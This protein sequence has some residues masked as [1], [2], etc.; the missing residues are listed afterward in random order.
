MAVDLSF[1]PAVP[2]FDA[3]V[4]LG[5]RYDRAVSVDTAAGTLTEMDRLGVQRALVYS[6]HAASFDTAEGNE[7]LLET[8]GEQSRLVPQFVANPAYDDLSSF[9]AGVKDAGVR[10]IRMYPALHF[11][12][13]RDWMIGPWLA[14]LAAEELPVWLPVG[15]D[16]SLWP[17]WRFDSNEVYDTLRASPDVTAVLTEVVYQQFSWAIPLVRSLPNLYVELS[18]W[19][20]IDGIPRLL[21]AVGDERILYGSRFPEG[22][23]GPQLYN[24]H[25]HGFSEETLGRICSGNLERLLGMR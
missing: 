12:P 8:I 21:E 11:Y 2:V 10:S 13:F 5:R 17:P 19:V 16:D 15:Y 3:N 25:H 20:M 22:A 14:W 24:L 4:A 7:I 1:K 9:A 23:M 18:R 6:P